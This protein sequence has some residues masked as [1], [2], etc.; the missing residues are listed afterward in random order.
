M[1]GDVMN[2]RSAS[3][4]GESREVPLPYMHKDQRTVIVAM[5]H[6]LAMGQAAGLANPRRVLAQA[7]ERA[8]ADGAILTPGAARLRNVVA[9]NLPW[10]LTAD[11]YANSV[12]PGHPGS[13]ELHG[14]LWTGAYAKR[15]GACG[16]KCLWVHGQSDSREHTASLESVA[17][18][19]EDAHHHDLSVMVES[20]MWGPRLAAT[21]QRDAQRVASAARMAYELGADIIK[22][23]MPETIGPLAEVA[24]LSPAPIVVM[25]GPVEQP[26]TL[27]GRIRDALDGGVRGVALGRNI[28]GARHVGGMLNALN[29]MVHD[30]CTVAEAMERMQASEA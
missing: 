5:D 7:G 17:R 18:L 8:R 27:F 2:Q 24:A 26:E 20:V 11:Y 9:P 28:W 15:M 29:G 6:A 1:E 21:H 12:D 19:I 14:M 10:L 30:D 25:G 23:A 13:E 16:V 22:V 3:D 4:L